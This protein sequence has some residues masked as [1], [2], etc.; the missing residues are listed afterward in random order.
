MKMALRL[1]TSASLAL[2]FA[3]T[4]AFGQAPPSRLTGTVSDASGTAVGRATVILSK[5][6]GRTEAITTSSA[7]G[8]YMFTGLQTGSYALQVFAVGFGP[9]R[10]TTVQLEDGKELKRD[11]TLDIGYVQD[12]IATMSPAPTMRQPTVSPSRFTPGDPFRPRLSEEGSSPNLIVKPEPAYPGLA[13]QARIEGIVIVEVA[14]GPDGAP[15]DIAVI[16]GHPLLQVPAIDAVKNYRYRPLVFNGSPTEFVT[17]VTVP[18]RYV[19]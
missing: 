3:A 15:K 14:V 11:L 13:K 1:V 8:A 17:T 10:M 6:E 5:V 2:T 16:S 9:S 12:S 7:A 4:T 18:F 19:P